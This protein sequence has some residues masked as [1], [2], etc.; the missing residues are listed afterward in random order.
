M[1]KLEDLNPDGKL[2]NHGEK[3]L[4]NDEANDEKVGGSGLQKR[5]VHEWEGCT[6]N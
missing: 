1:F 5:I 4:L 3:E 2:S 6:P